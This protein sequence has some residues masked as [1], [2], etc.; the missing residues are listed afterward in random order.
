MI[1]SYVRNNNKKKS[2]YFNYYR[3]GNR[4]DHAFWDFIRVFK[5]TNLIID[6]TTK[7]T[8]VIT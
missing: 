7:K 1:F 4:E 8:R 5:N 2:K 3:S 6:Y